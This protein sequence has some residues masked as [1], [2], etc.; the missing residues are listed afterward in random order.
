[1]IEKRWFEADF[2]TTGMNYYKQYGCTK[3]WLYAVSDEN[4]EIVNYGTDI[5]Q[6][7]SWLRTVRSS[8][9]YFHN[10][11]FDGNFLIDYL[12]RNGYPFNFGLKASDEKGFSVLVDDMGSLYSIKI[13]F[14]K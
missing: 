11:K 7:V 12:L 13:K 1:M 3:V 14:S 2:E 10:L 8:V 6:F 9:V 5:E 4:C